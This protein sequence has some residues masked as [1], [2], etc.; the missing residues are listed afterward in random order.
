MIGHIHSIETF[1]TLDGPGIR[2]VAFMQGCPLRC[3]FCHNPDTWNAQRQCQYNLTPEELLKEVLSYR[4]FYS[5]GGVTLSGGEPLMQ[6]NFVH[7]FFKLCHAEGLHT[8]LDTSGACLSSKVEEVLA[9]TD[10]VLLDIKTMDADLYPRL[11]GQ[12]QKNNLMFLDRLQSLGIPTWIRHVV[13]PGLTDNDQWLDRLGEHVSQ[14]SVVEKIEILPDGTIPQV[15][16]TSLGFEDSLNP[17]KVIPAEIACV[18][19]G[20]CYIIEKDT[21]TRP[22][23][24]IHSGAIIGYKYFDFGDDYSDGKMEFCAMVSGAGCKARLHILLDDYNDGK[25]IG[26]CMIDMHD[27]EYKVKCE[28]VT[29]RHAVYFKI[30]H[31]YEGWFKGSFENR[32]LFDLVAFAFKK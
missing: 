14:Y 24:N 5:S 26:C 23:S 29:G 13:V 32:N 18:L 3:M 17:Y 1:G 28:N 9:E 4:S 11:T 30:E 16:M 6:A 10:L 12:S 22:I 20:G 25:E 21:F 27:G 8:A 19:K 7:H 2:F 15:E 31:D